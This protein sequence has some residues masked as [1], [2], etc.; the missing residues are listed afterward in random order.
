VPHG[1][2][3]DELCLLLAGVGWTMQG[4]LLVWC[5]AIAFAGMVLAGACWCLLVYPVSGAADVLCYHY[6]SHAPS[7][8]G[9]IHIFMHWFHS[10]SN[11]VNDVHTAQGFG[12]V[13]ANI[14]G[15][16]GAEAATERLQT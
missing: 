8:K 6:M 11:L 1:A 2:D 14:L 15:P 13:G 3:A 4:L 7:R 5:M 12:G 9:C 10:G 16:S